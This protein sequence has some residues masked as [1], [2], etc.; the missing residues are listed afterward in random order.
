MKLKA[1]YHQERLWFIDRFES[2]NLYES[3]PIYHNIPFILEIQGTLETNKLEQSLQAVINR[4]EALRT[5]IITVENEPV[6]LIEPE[7][8]FKLKVIDWRDE[9][10]AGIYDRALEA[11]LEEV[12]QPFLMEK[13]LLIR[14]ALYRITARES[15][16]AIA[17]HHI[18]SDR[19]SLQVLA[20]EIISHYEAYMDDGTPQL[21]GLSIHYGD[22]SIFQWELPKKA[23]ESLFIHWKRQLV[24]SGYQPLELPTDNPRALVH[25][26]SEG[27]E[28]FEIPQ[29]LFEKI[30]DLG[31]KTGK[32]NFVLLLAAMKVLLHR[33][34]GQEEI[35]IGTS[36][37]NR[38]QPGTE[39]VIGPL[40][41][42]LPLY[43]RVSSQSTFATI[44]HSVERTLEKAIKYKDLPFEKLGAEL[45]LQ[46]DMSRTVLF[47]V[48]FQYEDR[49]I[50]IS[51]TR[52]MKIKVLETN[53]GWGKY[54]LNLLVQERKGTLVY[55][56]DYYEAATISRFT[57]HY[58]N[59][60][61]RLTADPGMPV[62]RFSFLTGEERHQLLV[63]WNRTRA[64]YPFAKTIIRLFEE[65][66]EK[67]P[68][69]TAVVY[70]DN[71]LTYRELQRQVNHLSG[72]LK[73]EGGVQGNDLV[74]LVLERSRQMITGLLA[75]LKAGGAYVPIDPSYPGKRIDYML[76]DSACSLLIIDERFRDKI[77]SEF[78]G[79][80]VALETI[81]HKKNEEI[82]GNLNKGHRVGS[83]D[84][85]AYVIYTSGT[86]GNPRGV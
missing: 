39:Q 29:P 78:N 80:I 41:N 68:Q 85:I 57:G 48:L 16:L 42:L 65:E 58:I 24:G 63:D 45:N 8:E 26:F 14:A 10:G 32:S 40:A 13:D 33:Y 71:Q 28:T 56:K 30:R 69:N 55:N 7:V 21:P 70:E 67:T 3:S 86:T 20:R 81:A 18:I 22:F 52:D 47:D 31:N 53:L 82:T 64:H 59:T 62:C 19:Y 6:Q 4:H 25:I 76:K 60:L 74:G 73:N 11:S 1:S 12:K 15:I 50:E 51:S 79:K 17:I 34:T 5:R 72:H 9:P 84:D 27:R 38:T 35:I 43:T 44:L 49:A 83:A 61:E 77:S 36:A 23:L 54:D 2:G 46:K 75:V 37:D 66:V